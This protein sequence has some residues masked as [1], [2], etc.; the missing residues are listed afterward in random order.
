MEPKEQGFYQ[1]VEEVHIE[2]RTDN[3]HDSCVKDAYSELTCT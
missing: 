3:S 2:Q 1:C